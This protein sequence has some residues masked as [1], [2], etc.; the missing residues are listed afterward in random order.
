MKYSS[1][2]D[3]QPWISETLMENGKD[4]F[5]FLFIHYCIRLAW[6]IEKSGSETCINAELS[7]VITID[8]KLELLHENVELLC[9]NVLNSFQGAS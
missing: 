6:S 9:Q 1:S 5:V 4:K 8:H 7:Q 3:V 2:A